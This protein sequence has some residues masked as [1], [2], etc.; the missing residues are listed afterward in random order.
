MDC[1]LVGG[2][3]RLGCRRERRECVGYPRAG[4]VGVL[5]LLGQSTR[6]RVV[7]GGATA[8]FGVD[9]LL[10]ALAGSLFPL[11]FAEA[12]HFVPLAVP[13]RPRA[14]VFGQGVLLD[15]HVLLV[16]SPAR[17]NVDRQQV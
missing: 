5:P 17:G 2:E 6:G 4:R 13:R 11:R 8:D 15:Y 1:W 10:A 12:V 3:G 7:G 9:D 16:C 14:V